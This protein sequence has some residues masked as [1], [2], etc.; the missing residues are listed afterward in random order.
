MDRDELLNATKHLEEQLLKLQALS[1]YPDVCAGLKKVRR[2]LMNVN[3]KL[4]GMDSRV[5]VI[6]SRLT[7]RIAS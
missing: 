3:A 4:L 7:D 5:Y 1:P 6:N 2:E